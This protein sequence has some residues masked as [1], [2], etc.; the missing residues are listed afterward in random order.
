M[1]NQ[2]EFPGD[3]NDRLGRAFAEL[4]SIRLRV[5]ADDSAA[6][7][8]A[9]AAIYDAISALASSPQSP[10][11]G[12]LTEIIRE[13]RTY[14]PAADAYKGKYIHK[15]WADRIEAASGAV[16]AEPG[17]REALVRLLASYS[18]LKPP[19][20][21]KS[22]AEKLAEAALA[23]HPEPAAPIE[24][25]QDVSDDWLTEEQRLYHEALKPFPTPS[26]RDDTKMWWA[27]RERAILALRR[28][29]HPVGAALSDVD[30]ACL[31]V[32][33]EMVRITTTVQ[34]MDEWPAIPALWL[35]CMRERDELRARAEEPVEY[36]APSLP[37][38]AART[39]A[40]MESVGDDQAA[41]I[42]FHLGWDRCKIFLA[43]P[44]RAVEQQPA[45]WRF[46]QKP[47]HTSWN[48]TD[49]DPENP[50]AVCPLGW[51]NAGHWKVWE[52]LY[53]AAPKEEPAVLT[54]GKGDGK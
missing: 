54:Q 28:P 34:G 10:G 43:A 17:L 21:P 7:S 13:L 53:L 20:Y 44:V 5:S 47:E 39:K 16:Q 50:T 19:G 30:K 9:R 29:A 42:A 8:K 32:G 38:L 12:A 51:G 41:R 24:A 11:G 6:L 33:R 45:A 37:E 23:A 25:V 4:G 22:D 26:E 3:L 14:N 49:L 18:R 35:N 15:G 2:Q 46:K 36:E 52:P 48:Y 31:E 27:W 40:R 1:T